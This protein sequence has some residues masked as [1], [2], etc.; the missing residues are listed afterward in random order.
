MRLNLYGV[1]LCLVNTHLT[2]HD[3]LLADRV[4]DYN[5]ILREHVYE[6]PDTSSIFYHESVYIHDGINKSRNN[7]I[8]AVMVT[9]CLQL[10]FLDRGFK[11]STAGGPIAVRHQPAGQA[12]PVG[13]SFR[14][15]PTQNSHGEWRSFRRTH[16]EQNLL[17]TNL[18]VRVWVSGF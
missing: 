12:E 1:S 5:T 14:E 11:F 15:R 9:C 10:H 8:A 6:A 2:P 18:Q 16:R 3:H 7:F 13:R 17:P 4:S